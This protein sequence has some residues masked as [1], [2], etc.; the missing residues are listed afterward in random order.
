MKHIWIFILTVAGVLSASAAPT[1]FY[2]SHWKTVEQA[3]SRDLPATALQSLSAIRRQA[4][5]E[6]NMPQ[7][8]RCL[9]QTLQCQV[10]ISPDSLQPCLQQLRSAMQAEQRPAPHAVYQYLLGRYQNDTTLLRSSL[11]DLPLLMEARATDYLP[12]ID[13]GKDSQWLYQ[14]DLLHLFLQPLSGPQWHT[15]FRAAQQAYRQR[16][17]EAAALLLMQRLAPEDSVLYPLWKQALE[18]DPSLKRVTPIAQ[19]IAR[20]EAPTLSL[21]RDGNG[22]LYPGQTITMVATARNMPTAQLKVGRKVYDLHFADTPVWQDRRDTL[23]FTIDSVGRYDITL[24][25]GRLSSTTTVHVSRVKPIMM[26]LPDGRCRI[27]LVDALTGQLL[28]DARLLRVHSKTKAAQTF[29]AAAD[30]FIYLSRTDFDSHNNNDMVYT[31]Q[32][33]TD[34]YHPAMERWHFHRGYFQQRDSITAQQV[35]LFTDREIYRPGQQVQVA[36]LS[37]LRHDDDYRVHAA[38]SLTLQLFDDNR[39]MLAQQP[40]V[41]DDFG[42]ASTQFSLPQGGL[43]GHYSFTVLRGGKNVLFHSFPV[44]EYKRPTLQIIL[45]P[46]TGTYQPGDT[47]TISGTARTFAGIPLADQAVWTQAG[48]TVLTDA[49]GRFAFSV[50][51]E[52]RSSWWRGQHVE[53]GLTASNGETATAQLY[54]PLPW[55]RTETEVA[56][57]KRTLPFWSELHTSA[58]GDE[59]TLTIGSRY[60]RC[61]AFIDILCQDRVVEHRRVVFTDSLRLP[62]RYRSEWQD[63]ATMQVAVV[64]DGQLHTATAQV[65]RPLP[66]KRLLFQWSTFRSALIPGQEESW[67]LRVTHPDGTPA[68]AMVMARMYDAS[69]QAFSHSDWG[70]SLDFQRSLPSTYSTSF[71]WNI[72]PLYLHT[73]LP[74]FKALALSQWR[75]GLFDY[76]RPHLREKVFLTA[77]AAAPMMK[78]LRVQG[79]GQTQGME[80]AAVIDMEDHAA[81]VAPA[82]APRS[83]FA[84][85]AF[86]RP[87]LHTDGQGSATLHFRLPESITSWH[88]TAFAYDRQLNFTLRHDTIVARKLLMAEIAAPRFLRDADSTLIP[89]TVTN[90]SDNE[91]QCTLSFWAD[92]RLQSQPVTLAAGE[93]RTLTFPYSVCAAEGGTVLLRTVL[94]SADYSDGEERLVPLLSNLTEV[95]RSIPFALSGAGERRIDLTPFWQ[96][97]REMGSQAQHVRLSIEQTSH[98]AW[99]VI[100]AL[101]PMLEERSESSSQKALHLYALRMAAFLH[102]YLPSLQPADST[103]TAGTMA[104]PLR[105]TL[106]EESPWVV[107]AQSEQERRHRLAE[108]LD[109]TSLHTQMLALQSELSRQQQDSGAWSWYPGMPAS[110]WTTTQIATTLA[111]LQRLTGH[112]DDLQAMLDKAMP[113]L[114][115]EMHATVLRMKDYEKR[116]RRTMSL[117]NDLFDYLYLC[118]LADQRS[119]ADISYLLN[120][121]QGYN[122]ALTIYGKAA[123]ALVL[124]HYGQSESSR[125]RRQARLLVRSILEH[126]VETPEMGRYFDTAQ[127]LSSS[128]SY[129]IPTQVLT[130][131]ALRQLQ[132]AEVEKFCLWLLQSRRTQQ[133]M[134]S[135]ATADACYA[136]ISQYHDTLTPDPQ[137]EGYALQTFSDEAHIGMPSVTIRQERNEPLWGAAYVQYLVPQQEVQEHHSGLTLSRQFSLPLDSLQVGD[138]LRITYTLTAERDMDFVSLRASRAACTE[139]LRPLSGY[140]YRSGAY[141]AVRDQRTDYFFEH[142]PKG[143]HTFTEELVIDRA[144]HYT[145]GTATAECVYAPEFRATAGSTTCT[146]GIIR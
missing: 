74:N 93:R 133:W 24:S 128:I 71:D 36:L 64:R 110:V 86:F 124:S 77:N 115:R 81:V 116:T 85:T 83:D 82:A 117:T 1:D 12:L 99:Q 92:D 62:L 26:G 136:I 107:A 47:V 57:D 32:A 121:L 112:S 6:Q 29:R 72:D 113:Y 140:D 135:Q 18:A 49:E 143:S 87:S 69:L 126:S 94:S 103:L 35:Q 60:P 25:S 119:S 102:Q 127:A 89:V 134:T 43:P 38:D 3:L 142:L 137:D 45:D 19:Y 132:P 39:Q 56:P 33:G 67:T 111:R 129:K 100:T 84:E 139:P 17:N 108:L 8:C 88:F 59:A 41:T 95:V 42:N 76:Y 52:N 16:G 75:S 58:S 109:S 101:A 13:Y 122:H 51:V 2:N 11:A 78:A 40:L 138:R 10:E 44:E 114:H 146:V 70:F 53:V 106:L 27:A 68:D 31:P 66:D 123:S 80:E 9:F 22:V 55:R 28:P 91:Q 145:M 5:R 21:E 96:E 130:I 131:E 125:Y 34:T 120:K 141:R 54:I 20:M 98:P 73:Q 15:T 4:I 105:Q 14:D 30:G 50:R 79:N 7:L 48:D 104:S 97:L 118:Y 23:R 46:L 37:Y 61:T 65:Q 144:G 90:L 63:G